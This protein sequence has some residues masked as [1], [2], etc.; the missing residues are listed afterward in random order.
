MSDI[1]TPE[2]D[3][4]ELDGTAPGVEAPNGANY[5]L[6]GSEGIL[7][8][9]GDMDI[10]EAQSIYA[11]ALAALGDSEASTISIDL[12]NVRRIDLSALQILIALRRDF[13]SLEQTVTF[14]IPE[15]LT[16]RIT[17]SGIPL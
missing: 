1:Q 4:V 9:R 7:T 5:F 11:A 16:E 2:D 14:H 15:E 17:R 6:K 8:L 13:E 3:D 10:F 12:M